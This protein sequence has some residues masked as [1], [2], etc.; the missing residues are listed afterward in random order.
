MSRKDYEVEEGREI[1]GRTIVGGRPA[2]HQRRKVRV[3]IG[4]EKLLVRAAADGDFRQRLQDD[5][6]AVLAE[7]GDE[8]TPVERSVLSTIPE[9]SLLQMVRS[10][11]LERH[12]K[13]RF[14]RGV[15]NAALVTSAAS[16]VLSCHV[17]DG[18]GKGCFPDQPDEPDIRVEEVNV[19][20]FASRGVRPDD[21]V[22]VEEV[23]KPT[24]Q[25]E[26]PA[27][28][29]EVPDLPAPTGIM[30]VIEEPE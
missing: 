2:A 1:V 13:K 15:V 21:L 22:A 24:D 23:L 11:D 16:A 10:I 5:R 9:E 28:V 12:T 14:M 29:I 27:D 18:Q 25:K 30:P 7:L 4:I 19:E 8:L 17:Q 20:D 3:P 6:A 26:E